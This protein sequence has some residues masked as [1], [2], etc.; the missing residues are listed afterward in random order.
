MRTDPRSLPVPDPASEATRENRVLLDG[1]GTD[2]YSG[3]FTHHSETGR[4]PAFLAAA[5]TGVHLVLLQS[6]VG[7]APRI[8]YL[9]S[10][11]GGTPFQA[12][13]ILGSVEANPP[14]GDRVG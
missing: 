6:G 11:D 3:L 1:S 5:G 9:R 14:A 10:S 8:L 13:Q 12:P 4:A 7:L 2:L